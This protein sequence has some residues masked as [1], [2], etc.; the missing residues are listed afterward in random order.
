[1]ADVTTVNPLAWNFNAFE[2]LTPTEL[3]SGNTMP[4]SF[5]PSVFSASSNAGLTN[6]GTQLG[7]NPFGNYSS[8]G[9]NGLFD[10]VGSLCTFAD[11]F[12]TQTAPMI[13][14]AQAYNDQIFN[15]NLY[16]AQQ[17]SA[18]RDQLKALGIN[19]DSV[20]NQNQLNGTGQTNQ[21]GS[22]LGL[23]GSGGTTGT[24]ANTST[25]Q[26]GSLLGLLG[27]GGT[28]ANTGN[29]QLDQLAQALGLGGTTQTATNTS[30]NQ[31]GSLLG[32]LGLGGTTGTTKTVDDWWNHTDPYSSSSSSDDDSDSDDAF[33]DY[34]DSKVAQSQQQSQLQQLLS[35]LTGTKA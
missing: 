8:L 4:Y 7:T 30:T 12:T 11:T 17:T 18:L 1:M 25:D 9:M 20:L 32:L 29:S 34:I 26:L 2:Y 13:A 35:L 23:L 31:L 21:L 28:T 24:T 27:L 19:P 22:L 10:N 33:W 3:R 5:S 16:Q 14:Q 6:T 15:Q